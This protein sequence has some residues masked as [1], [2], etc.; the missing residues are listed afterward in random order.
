MGFVI[1][2]HCLFCEERTE[3]FSIIYM[4]FGVRGSAVGWGTALQT[5]R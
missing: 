2:E 1:Q 5:G 3:Y 4:N